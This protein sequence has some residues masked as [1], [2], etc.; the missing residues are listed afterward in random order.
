LYVIRLKLTCKVV[1]HYASA[2]GWSLRRIAK[3]SCCKYYSETVF[4]H[5]G[6]CN[7]LLNSQLVKMICCIRSNGRVVHQNVSSYGFS[8]CWVLHNWNKNVFEW[9]IMFKWMSNWKSFQ[10]LSIFYYFT[11]PIRLTVLKTNLFVCFL[12]E[13]EDTKKSFRNYLI[14]SLS[15]NFLTVF[16]QLFDSWFVYYMKFDTYVFPQTLQTFFEPSVLESGLVGWCNM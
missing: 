3:I 7:V 9:M 5:Y 6:F 14:F 1:L 13:S 4:P 2:Y 10:K 16:C 11:W 8:K 12:E 15:I